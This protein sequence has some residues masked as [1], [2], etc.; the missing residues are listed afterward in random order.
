MYVIHIFLKKVPSLHYKFFLIG[1]IYFQLTKQNL[2]NFILSLMT[3]E[4][5]LPL[6]MINQMWTWVDVHF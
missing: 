2:D 6:C 1:C 3:F 4:K 5:L